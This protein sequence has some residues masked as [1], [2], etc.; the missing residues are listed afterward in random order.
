MAGL[1]N[2]V[3]ETSKAVDGLS[4]KVDNL[5]T[6]ITSAFNLTPTGLLTTLKSA[7]DQL[8]KFQ[9][10]NIS[11]ARSLGQGAGFAK[12]IEGELG[13]AAVNIVAMGGKLEDV[14]DI[15]K[16]INNELGRTTFLSEKFL[17]NAKAIKTFGVDE[18][19]INSFGSFFDKVGGGMDASMSKQIELVNTAQKYGLNTGQFLTTVAGKLD[20]LT[21]Y[22]FPKGVNDLASM[23]AKSQVLGDTLSVA[24]NFADQIMDSPEK[25]FEYAA[26]LQTLGGSF[27]QLGDGAQLLYM[28]QNDLKGLNDQLINATRGIATFNEESGQFEISA[29]ERLRLRGLKNLG[30][31]ADKIEEAALKLAKNEK[32]LSGFKGVAFDGMSEEDKQTLVNISEVGKGGEIKIGGKGLEELNRSPETLTK[33]LEQVQNKGNQLSTD[34]SNVDVVQSQMS[35]NEQL[36]TST[37]QLNTMFASTIITTDNF[38]VGLDTMANQLTQVGGTMNNFVTKNSDVMTGAY[39][40]VLTDLPKTIDD[41]VKTFTGGVTEG[42]ALEKPIEV[43]QVVTIKA[44]GLDVDFANIIKPIIK[45]YLESRIKKVALKSGYS[46]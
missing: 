12:S 34:K 41:L 30:I 29:N 46:E 27:S 15:Y 18:K 22:G 38:S 4:K 31:D 9:D 19:T 28:A 10:K 37:N 21:K 13:R 20:I 16:G 26:Q 39:N 23:V 32:I 14:I 1:E 36:T 5:Q 17:V 3:D 35:A 45:D 40:K 2:T 7:V 6:A 33:L 11:V 25:A 24:Q 43:N 8:S 44:E 42:K